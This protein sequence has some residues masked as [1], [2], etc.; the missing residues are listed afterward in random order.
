MNMNIPSQYS[1]DKLKDA[2]MRGWYKGHEVA[3]HNVPTL[4]EKI[5]SASMGRVTIDAD[6]IRDV[7]ADLTYEAESGSRCYSPFEF[8]AHEFNSDEDSES[9]WDAFEAGVSDAISADLAEYTDDDYGIP[10][11]ETRE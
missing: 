2:Y 5:Y 3:C 7:H 1:A 11:Q 10:F 4:G 8:I 6:N 9:L